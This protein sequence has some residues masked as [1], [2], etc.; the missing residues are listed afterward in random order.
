MPCRDEFAILRSLPP[1]PSPPPSPPRSPPRELQGHTAASSLNSLS[2]SSEADVLAPV[3]S[4]FWYHPR[5]H[6]LAITLTA[7]PL[8]LK[9]AGKQL[10]ALRQGDG[11]RGVGEG[12]GIEGGGGGRYGGGVGE[13]L[14]EI[15]AVHVSSATTAA[16]SVT[17][18]RGE[19]TERV[20]R[21]ILLL[22]A[23]DMTA[24]HRR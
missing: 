5:L 10:R 2:L 8:L 9:E 24:W 22:T 7:L 13:Q 14:V 11:R 21:V 6:K 3:S 15:E 16:V 12:I 18:A 17:D 20:T 1:P 4:F 23:D 19:E